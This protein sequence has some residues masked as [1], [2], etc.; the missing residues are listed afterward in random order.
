MGNLLILVKLIMNNVEDS[1][2][3][4]FSSRCQPKSS[5]FSFDNIHRNTMIKKLLNDTSHHSNDKDNN[6]NADFVP[7]SRKT[8]TTVVGIVYKDGVIIGADTRETCDDVVVNKLCNKIHYLA[9]NIYCCA[10]GTSADVNKTTEVISSELELHQMNT[11]MNQ[12]RVV[13]A[14]ALLKRKLYRYQGYIGASVILGGCDLKGPQVYQINQH[15]S[16]S[17]LPFTTMGSGSLAAMS[18]FETYWMEDMSE[19]SALNLVKRAVAAGVFNDLGSGS[20]VDICVIR[21]DGTVT[22]DRSEIKMNNVQSFRDSIRESER[23]SFKNGT[24]SVLDSVFIPH[25]EP[26]LDDVIVTSLNP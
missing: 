13:T 18:I 10:A 5:G 19:A 16:T 20:N 9:P 11:G 23:L 21:T 26:T 25:R 2:L 12:L 6:K 22:I 7:L 17:K 8:G 14:C 24:T 1:T 3:S 4:H 15:G